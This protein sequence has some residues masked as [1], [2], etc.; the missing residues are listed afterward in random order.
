MK[1][2]MSCTD[3]YG[4]Q[5][6]LTLKNR[7]DVLKRNMNAVFYGDPKIDIRPFPNSGDYSIF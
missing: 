7:Y 3:D 6:H 4:R 1:M 5:V 2:F